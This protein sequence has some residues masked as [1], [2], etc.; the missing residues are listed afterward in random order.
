MNLF[1]RGFNEGDIIGIEKLDTIGNPAYSVLNTSRDIAVPLVWAERHKPA[2]LVSLGRS[3]T[4]LIP[5]T[6]LGN[7]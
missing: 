4:S 1:L 5:L 6:C 2:N 7:P 3:S